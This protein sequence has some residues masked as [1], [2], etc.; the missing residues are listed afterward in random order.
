MIIL[1][2]DRPIDW[3]RPPLAVF[4]LLLVN[5]LVYFGAQAGDLRAQGEAFRWY[6]ESGLA[7][8][9]LPRYRD[10]LVDNGAREFVNEHGD[11]L[12]EPRGPW[13]PHLLSNGRF[14]QALA[15]GEIIE[16]ADDVYPEWRQ[17]R[18]RFE[19]R[20]DES[21]A[22]R[23]GLRPFLNEPATW[24]THMFLHGGIM[25]LVG[26]MIFLVAVGFL[27]EIALGSA[28]LLV[29]YLV[30]GLGAAALYVTVNP[31]G[32]M[33]LVGA[34]GAIAGLMGMLPVVYGLQRIRFFYFVG[35]YFDYV[36]A[37]AL[38]LLPAWLGYELFQFLTAGEYDA[39]AY[40]AHIGGLLAG[41]AAATAI[42][43][44]TAW[45][46][47]ETVAARDREEQIDD[48]LEEVRAAAQRLEPEAGRAALRRLWS[49]FPD[50]QRILQAHYE[51]ARLRP[52]EAEIHD[53]AR[54]ILA[55]AGED[56]A[57]RDWVR[58]TWH[59]YRQRA[60]PKPRLDAATTERLAGVMLASGELDQAEVLIRPMLKQPQRFQ[61]P[62]EL[63]VR[64][65]TALV[66]AGE[67]ERAQRWYQRISRAWPDGELRRRAARAL[68]RTL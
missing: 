2:L 60:R 19:R 39:V 43:F 68:G 50:D 29:L 13:L 44:G 4:G 27:V 55:T 48:G 36:K 24:L 11:A 34:S 33:P 42:R 8:I 18:L 31:W 32:G 1:P 12:D 49:R 59:D 66:K 23:W 3:R 56:E 6:H 5:V 40:S 52:A 65:I 26:N 28:T 45:I 67:R 61:H 63:V 62:G 53:A 38:V 64:L 9:E 14:Q 25:H 57:T 22:M 15:A 10:W 30:T 17:K 37:P 58:R 7:E 16:P 46:D 35:V 54:A 41:A 51:L 20:L 21:T 47:H